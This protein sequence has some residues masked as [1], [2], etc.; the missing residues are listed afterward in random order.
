MPMLQTRRRLLAMLS[1]LGAG[2]FLRPQL[3]LA[4]EAPLE[5]TSVRLVK[6]LVNCEAPLDVAEELL[7]AEGFSD[8][9]YVDVPPPGIS[10]A[11]VLGQVDFGLSFPEFFLPHLDAGMPIK[12][13]AGVDVGCFALF[14]RDGIRTIAELKRRECRPQGEPARIAEANVRLSG[15][16]AGAA[17]AAGAKCR[18]RDPQYGSGPSL[19]AIFLLQGAGQPGLRP[20][21]PG[22]DKARA[23]RPSQNDRSLRRVACRGG[24]SLVD[25]S[26]TGR[27]G[28]ALQTLNDISYNNW[29]EYNAED[30]IRFYALRRHEAGLIKSSP[31]KI[32]GDGTDWRF[33]D[34]LKR[35]LKA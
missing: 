19:V 5:T 2:G 22:R 20:Q 14:A 26:F 24:R 27:Y 32:I 30:T 16:S 17:G 29:R 34:E 4:A 25:G 28:Y 1:T 31:Q 15:L 18:S 12:V 13:L 23:A 6:D 11:I 3:S 35:E 10:Q 33:L 9:R 7:R 21:T 8:V